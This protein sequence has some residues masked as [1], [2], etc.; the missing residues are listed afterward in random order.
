MNIKDLT[1]LA[2][3]IAKNSLAWSTFEESTAE[4]YFEPLKFISFA[5]VADKGSWILLDEYGAAH[6]FREYLNEIVAISSNTGNYVFVNGD[7]VK[8]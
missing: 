8:I 1:S 4:K 3:F 2:R 6:V 5:F 7:T